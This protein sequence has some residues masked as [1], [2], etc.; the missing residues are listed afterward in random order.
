MKRRSFLKSIGAA[1]TVA[2][3]FPLIGAETRAPY[4]ASSNIDFN[5][6]LKTDPNAEWV[7]N[8]ET[9]ELIRNG[10]WYEPEWYPPSGLDRETNF[11]WSTNND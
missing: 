5:E 6:N 7:F 10:G 11:E 2:A 1:A 4:V 9:E 3:L 8:S